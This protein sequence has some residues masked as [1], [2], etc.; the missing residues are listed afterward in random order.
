MDNERRDFLLP[1]WSYAMFAEVQVRWHSAEKRTASEMERYENIS[2]A[3][4]FQQDRS[5]LRCREDLQ[6]AGLK[7]AFSRTN[8]VLMGVLMS[9]TYWKNENE[10][11]CPKHLPSVK[12]PANVDKCFFSGCYSLRPKNRPGNSG[13]TVPRPSPSF[14]TSAMHRSSKPHVEIE[15]GNLC[16]W[17]KCEKGLNETRST[18]RSNSKYCSRDCSNRNAR[19]RHKQRKK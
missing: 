7:P 10:W 5:T 12:L 14:M 9:D 19:W 2:L 11:V 17:F 6:G 4:L 15:E 3:F 13:T 16:A 18:I 1:K 8:R